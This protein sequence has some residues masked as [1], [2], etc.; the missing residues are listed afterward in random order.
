M[1]IAS[2]IEKLKSLYDSGVITESEFTVAK[3]KLLNTIGPENT[4]GTGVNQIGRAA[5]RWVDLQWASYAVGLIA[6]VLFLIF[7]F[8]P[9]WQDMKKDEAEFNAHFNQTKQQIEQ[10]H[11]D[12][13]KRSKKFDQDFEKQKQEMDAFRKKNFPN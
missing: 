11:E 8:I 5:N 3:Q 4:T 1:S 10:A 6:S 13:E 2:E 12:L 9:F 7:F